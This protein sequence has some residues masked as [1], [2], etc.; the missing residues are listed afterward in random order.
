MP[1]LREERRFVDGEAE[2]WWLDIQPA[3]AAIDPFD[4]LI[5]TDVTICDARWLA[6]IRMRVKSFQ[7]ESV[8][9]DEV[10]C[11]PGQQGL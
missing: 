4:S 7:R 9:R 2:S 11:V 6:C 5:A 1:V 3:S 8:N 10:F